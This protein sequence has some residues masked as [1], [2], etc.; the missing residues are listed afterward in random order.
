MLGEE[1]LLVSIYA[2]FGSAAGDSISSEAGGAER[3]GKS[4]GASVN[5]FD[6]ESFSDFSAKS[7]NFRRLVQVKASLR[8]DRGELLD[9]D[10]VQLLSGGASG[11]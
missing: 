3:A 11:P 2:F 1:L 7:S 8:R 9:L 10:T 6:T 4:A 5:K